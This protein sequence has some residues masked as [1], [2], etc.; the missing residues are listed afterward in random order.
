MAG[1]RP[2]DVYNP[3]TTVNPTVGMPSDYQTVQANPNDFGAQTGVA[4]QGLGKQVQEATNQYVNV[5]L[6]RQGMINETMATDAE[7]QAASSYGSIVGAYRATEG[8][9]AV[10]GLP[11]VVQDLQQVRQNIRTSLPNPAAQRAFDMLASR[12]EAYALQDVNS[13]AASQVKAADT[14]SANAALNVA[15][16]QAS[17]PTVAFNP[18]QFNDAVSTVKFQSARILTNMGYGA[19]AGTGMKQEKDGSLT[20]DLST[21]NGKKAKDVYDNYIQDALGKVW[22]NRINTLAFDPQ[23]GNVSTAISTLIDNKDQIPSN[24]YASLSSKLAPALK[25]QQARSIASSLLEP[26][27]NY[28]ADFFR[29]NYTDIVDK[30]RSEAQKAH[31][32]DPTFE[33]QTVSRVEQ[34]MGDVIRQQELMTRANQDGV[35][36]AISGKFNNKVPLTSMDQIDNGP[37]E[38]RN[39][40]HNWLAQDPYADVKINRL[41][42]ANQRGQQATY[43]TEFYKHLSDALGG[44]IEDPTSLLKNY[45]GATKDSPLT[46]TGYNHIFKL[47]QESSTP[48]SHAFN[49]AELKF[50]QDM[51]KEYTGGDLVGMSQFEATPQFNRAI[52]EIIPRIEAGRRAGKTPE[53]LFSPKINGKDN[54]DYITS[55]I[56]PPDP[57]SLLKSRLGSRSAI[58]D[59]SFDT[60][61]DMK[62]AFQEKKIT[63]EQ[64]ASFLTKNNLWGKEGWPQA[65]LPQVP[66]PD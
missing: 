16:D 25:N 64:A 56:K 1:P 31:P 7:T 52:Q 40:Y 46:N 37:P 63:K 34:R 21:D 12:R 36:A 61:D 35:L 44:T 10:H 50:L 6:Q 2:Q 42:M 32:D 22:T 3:N 49:Q 51:H 4:L 62:K 53:Q 57:M 55:S 59:N 48:E 33:D 60:Y 43:G 45:V 8:L 5:G 30:A 65:P 15:I 23:I 24:T 66:L 9:E 54:P 19:D 47:T 11:K 58:N 20:F 38:V 27:Q 41:L 18:A 13:Y 14:K 17:D 39:A 29:S 28:G 26:Y